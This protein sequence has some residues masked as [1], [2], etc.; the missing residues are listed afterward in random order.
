MKSA[1][2]RSPSPSHCFAM[3]PSSPRFAQD[4]PG[5]IDAIGLTPE[6]SPSPVAKQ[7]ERVAEGRV[8]ALP[9]CLHSGEEDFCSKINLTYRLGLKKEPSSALRAPSPTLRA[10]EGENLEGLSLVDEI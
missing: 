6:A 8:R 2:I 5:K 9:V 3:S 1:L 4:C 10:G 7:W